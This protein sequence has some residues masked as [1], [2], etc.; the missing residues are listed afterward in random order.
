MY[1]PV[2]RITHVSLYSTKP[3]HFLHLSHMIY[4]LNSNPLA[5]KTHDSRFDPHHHHPPTNTHL[6]ISVQ[7]SIN[8]LTPNSIPPHR[9][10]NPCESSLNPF[11]TADGST[12][13]QAQFGASFMGILDLASSFGTTHSAGKPGVSSVAPSVP[14]CAP[15]LR[16]FSSTRGEMH[17]NSRSGGFG[18]GMLGGAGGGPAGSDPSA[19]SQSVDTPSMHVQTSHSFP[20]SG[21]LSHPRRVTDAE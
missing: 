10:L 14:H 9:G 13:L 7:N 6:H 5:P 12:I 15:A 11:S 1:I 19:T 4:H 2:Q 3:S 17:E 18:A 20:A 8:L 21:A 16:Q